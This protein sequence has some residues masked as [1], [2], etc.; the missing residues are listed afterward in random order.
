[1]KDF[2]PYADNLLIVLEPLETQTKSGIALVRS[3]GPGAKEHRTARVIASGPGHKRPCCGTFV[4]NETKPGDRVIV[5]ALAG[6]RQ[7]F[8]WDLTAPRHNK[9]PGFDELFGERAEYRVIRE[10]EVLAV[11]EAEQAAAE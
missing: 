4:P 2:V 3:S 1:M 7:H 6:D 5:D 10:D 11:I 9:I 8:A